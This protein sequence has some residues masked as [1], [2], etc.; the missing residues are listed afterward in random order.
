MK[1]RAK[2]QDQIIDDMIKKAGFS[3]VI[4][5]TRDDNPNLNM[6]IIKGSHISIDWTSGKVRGDASIE[7]AIEGLPLLAVDGF[8]SLLL[9]HLMHMQKVLRED[10][11]YNDLGILGGVPHTIQ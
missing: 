3:Y 1:S 2:N 10:K 6:L 11:N 8:L 9:D 4:S 7:S 5:A